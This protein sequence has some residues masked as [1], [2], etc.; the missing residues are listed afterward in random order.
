VFALVMATSVRPVT[1]TQVSPS[2][3]W[4][5][6]GLVAAGSLLV[7]G[8]VTAQALDLT[9]VAIVLLVAAVV[10]LAPLALPSVER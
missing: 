4:R 5:R 1:R 2:R 6:A 3:A 10:A 7:V 9:P 8:S